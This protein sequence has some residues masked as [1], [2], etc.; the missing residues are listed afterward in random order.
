MYSL[1]FESWVN[2]STTEHFFKKTE[3]HDGLRLSISASIDSTSLK[4][5]H[6]NK[7][8]PFLHIVRGLLLIARAGVISIWS[9]LE[10]CWGPAAG[11]AISALTKHSLVF[12]GLWLLGQ[13]T[14]DVGANQI[15]QHLASAGNPTQP[16]SRP[17]R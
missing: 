2:T 12:P 10:G 14:T 6:I 9:G 7:T 15:L 13:I 1:I 17:S 8:F 16:D 4:I 5:L 3:A 11:C